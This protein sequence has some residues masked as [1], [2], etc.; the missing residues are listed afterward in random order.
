MKKL[1]KT[2]QT[3]CA[4]EI[5]I[6]GLRLSPRLS[7]M[8]S[9][10]FSLSLRLNLSLRLSLNLSLSLSLRLR[11]SLPDKIFQMLFFKNL[12]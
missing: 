10:R 2:K 4:R 5:A 9:L 6:L 12:T 1:L 3:N 11:L 7:L 8:L